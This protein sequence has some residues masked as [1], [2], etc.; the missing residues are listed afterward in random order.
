MITLQGIEPGM[1]ANNL[2]PFKP[3]HPGSLLKDELEYRH[4]PQLQFTKRLKLPNS[5]FNEILNG[6]RPVTIDFALL[7]EAALN[8]PAYILIGLQTDYNLQIA[9]NDIK[10][11]ERL[12]EVR[13]L[14]SLF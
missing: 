8:I 9:K 12:A 4:I 1:I 14:V 7:M 13:K 5:A 11:R 2:T 6:K 3:T 10:L